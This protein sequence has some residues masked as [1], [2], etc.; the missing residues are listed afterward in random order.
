MVDIAGLARQ[1]G[2]EA[3]RDPASQMVVLSGTRGTI[4]FNP[5]LSGVLIG[6]QVRF[7]GHHVLI[8]NGQ[9]SVPAGFVAECEKLLGVRVGM[10]PTREPA[11]R[12]GRTFQVVLDPGHGGRDPGAIG[13]SGRYEKTV[14]LS[15]AHVVA[16]ELRARGVSVTMT[17]SGD[18]F[19]EVDER[20]A[21][22]NR[23]RADA[24]VSIHSDVSVSR[25]TT[26]YTVYVVHTN[27][28]DSA[29]ASMV[30]DEYAL[31]LGEYNGGRA[32]SEERRREIVR[33]ILAANRARS[34]RLASLI[35]VQLSSATYT[36]DRGTHLGELRVVKRAVCP[37]VLVELGFMSNAAEEQMLFQSDYQEALGSAIAKGIILFLKGG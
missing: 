30:A 27:Y 20:A 10:Q 18:N 8:A 21:I 9:V 1:L 19:V 6:G 13:V 29:R 15:V 28:S 12:T 2:M 16:A 37:A 23:L 26:G 5:K 7:R 32:A 35:R 24:F 11:P 3:S 31:D 14:N 33:S 25:S 4:V 17:R 36:T 22:G 34:M